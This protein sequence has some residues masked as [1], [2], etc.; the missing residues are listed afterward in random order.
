MGYCSRI[1]AWYNSQITIWKFCSISWNT[2]IIAKNEHNIKFLSTNQ[3]LYSKIEDLWKNV[4]IWNDVW[5]GA[6]C[7]ILPWVTIWNGAIVWA[8]AIVTKNIPDY[9]I[10]A[11]NPAKIIKYRFDSNIIEKLLKEKWWNWDIKKIKEN[12]DLEKI[13]NS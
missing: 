8:W 12:I 3:K 13:I 2:S 4:I 1:N 7:V 6:N 10:V 5:I 9:A 11:W